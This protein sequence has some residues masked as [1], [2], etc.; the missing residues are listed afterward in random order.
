[1][2]LALFSFTLSISA[3]AVPQSSGV[4]TLEGTTW[5][6]IGSDK[7]SYI[8]EF[9]KAFKLRY[10]SGNGTSGKGSWKQA[11]ESISF[12][13]NSK[14]VEFRGALHINQMQGES[15][16]RKGKSLKWSGVRE[17]ATVTTPNAPRYPG[18]AAA[19]HA[20]GTVI[21]EVTIDAKGT[22][23]LASTIEGHPLLRRLCEASAKGWRFNPSNEGMDIR[24]VRLIFFFSLLPPDCKKD[25]IDL[26]PVYLSPYLVNVRRR[27]VCPTY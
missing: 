23:I 12:E 14:S 9:Q 6:I 8:F 25:V 27:E 2:L 7:Q 18:I 21:I 24:T 1:M 3:R 26:S 10:F 22:V 15:K 4:P 13:V 5:A 20:S 19:A 16:T 17:R 11:A